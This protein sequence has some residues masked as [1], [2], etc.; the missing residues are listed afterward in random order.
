MWLG[1]LGIYYYTR[2]YPTILDETLEM[3]FFLALPLVVA[4]DAIKFFGCHKIRRSPAQC[5]QSTT[6]LHASKRTYCCWTLLSEQSVPT[7]LLQIDA[8]CF[9]DIYM[10]TETREVLTVG[11][12]LQQT[13]IISCLGY[14]LPVGTV[15]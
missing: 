4:C 8:S 12:F 2:E 1:W 5:D 15:E 10:Y 11:P 6:K 3:H 13:S 7:I 9:V 14:P